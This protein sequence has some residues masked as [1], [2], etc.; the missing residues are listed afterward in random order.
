MRPLG[1]T[2]SQW[3]VLSALSRSHNDGMMQVDLARLLEVG[4]VTVGGLIDRLEET[5][6]VVR[7]GDK[8][9]RR[10]KRIFVT[11]QGWQVIGKMIQVARKINERVLAGV[12]G[13]DLEAT[14]RTL[15]KVKENI[16]QA[17]HERE[18]KS[19]P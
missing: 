17:L 1:L 16:K 7:K 5:G 9:D 8:A 15:I 10:A 14:E 4:K 13:E 6:H 3:S 19:K 2:R 11:E 18:S 12:P